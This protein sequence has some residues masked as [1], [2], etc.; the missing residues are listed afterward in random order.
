MI[1]KLK[2]KINILIE[3]EE[4]GYKLD[5]FMSIFIMLIPFIFAILNE[6]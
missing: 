3:S 1:N 4:F 6:I 2:N 5:F